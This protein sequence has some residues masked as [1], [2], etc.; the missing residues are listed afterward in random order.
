MRKL[1][2]RILRLSSTGSF[3]D[4]LRSIVNL[5]HNCFIGESTIIA[6]CSGISG[7]VNVEKNCWLGPNSSVIDGISIG[8]GVMIGIGSVVDKSLDSK[9]KVMGLASMPLR[10]LILLKLF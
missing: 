1:L 3:F 4:L 6:A 2:L 8:E 5:S 7:S 10:R 9:L